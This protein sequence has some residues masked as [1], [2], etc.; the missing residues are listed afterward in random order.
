MNKYFNEQSTI[1][2]TGASSGIGKHLSKILTSVYGAKVIGVAR[3]EEKLSAIKSELGD[4][5]TYLTADVSI[6]SEWQ[7]LFNELSASSV[8]IT[9]LIN[10]AGV[11]PKFSSFN[12][13]YF[14]KNKSVIDVN[15]LSV[16]YSAKYFLSELTNQ[17]YPIM[18]N[19]SSS[20]ALCPFGGI[21]LYSATKAG[22]ERF[23]ESLSAENK[24]LKVVTV[25]PGFTKTEVLR[26]QNASEKEKGLI[27]KI[28]AKPEKVAKKILKRARKGKTRIITGFDAHLM[29]FLFKFFPRTAPR[30]I[31][32]FLKKTKM[33]IFEEI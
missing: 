28:S 14:D 31:G 25:M 13:E 4:K 29:N 26:S 18:I 2:V 5:F 11:L 24:K 17:P 1:L 20:S 16:I 30:L 23:S 12:A 8:K 27:D 32:W 6:E 7:K 21:S 22:V 9:G 19:V 10:C 15:F 33:K 3:S